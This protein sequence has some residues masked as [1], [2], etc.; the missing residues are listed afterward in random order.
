[1]TEQGDAFIQNGN[2]N[3]TGNDLIARVS[4][5]FLNGANKFKKLSKRNKILIIGSIVIIIV[6]IV[7]AA[8][9]GTDVE[10]KGN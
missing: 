6:V 3:T 2:I 1:M 9:L 7:T 5:P 4:A 10:K 8:S